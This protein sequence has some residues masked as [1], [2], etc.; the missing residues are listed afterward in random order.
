MRYGSFG[1][2]YNR[3]ST[4]EEKNIQCR[5]A[6]EFER[7]YTRFLDLKNAEA[8]VREAQ[9]QL[10]LERVRA[11][12]MAMHSSKELDSIIK[13]VYSELKKLDVLFELCFIMI[14]D[15]HKGATWWMGSP[16]DDLF[17]EGFY[18]PYHTHPPHLA[19]LQGWEERQQKWEYWL[20]D[21]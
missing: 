5:F 17:H 16:D 14:F 1:V 21:K 4:D 10:A 13:T 6:I 18:V 2:L 7:A 9:I 12:T 3:P 20:E 15:E 8:Q 11:R 19:Y